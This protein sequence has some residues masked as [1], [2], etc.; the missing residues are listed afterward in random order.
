M[1]IVFQ[2]QNMTQIFVVAFLIDCI[3]N[4]MQWYPN[5]SLTPP[6]V[7]TMPL[8]FLICGCCLWYYI[9]SGIYRSFSYLSVSIVLLLM[10]IGMF[11]GLFAVD[12]YWGYKGW[13][14]CVH[15]ALSVV[16]LFPLGNPEIASK[17]L[18]NWN[19]YIVPVFFLIGMWVLK[20]DAYPFQ[21][22]FIYYFYVLLFTIAISNQKARWIIILGVICTLIAIENRSAIIKTVVAISLCSTL[23]LHQAIRKASLFLIHFFCYLGPVILLVLGLTG[24]FNIFQDLKSDEPAEIVSYNEAEGEQ[25]EEAPDLTADT[26]TFLYVEVIASAIEGDY[27]VFGNSIGRGNTSTLIWTD[28]EDLQSERL[29]NEAHMLNIFTWMGILGIIFYTIMYLQSSC[30]GLFCSKNRYV[31]LI[32]CAVAFHWAMTWL[33]ECPSFNPMDYALFLLLGICF[34][35]KFRRMTDAEFKIWFLS[36]F[37]D[38]H[39]FSAFDVLNILKIKLLLTNTKR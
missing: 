35:P 22:P 18:R 6:F 4:M 19:K 37:A 16:L 24:T 33:E 20:F 29:M 32:A 31:P 10:L 14:N 11:R 3:C 9:K 28:I 30:L 23:F 36:C 27:M 25:N 39:K 13:V 5:N 15:S 2:K 26:R 7:L 17:I 1:P 21:I 8:K 12:G 34:S 38:P